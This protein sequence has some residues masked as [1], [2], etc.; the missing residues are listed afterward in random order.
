MEINVATDSYYKPG[1]AVW[2][3]YAPYLKVCLDC[4]RYSCYNFCIVRE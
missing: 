4:T 3:K 2:L 1:A